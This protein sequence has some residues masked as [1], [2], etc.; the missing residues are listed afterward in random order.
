[1]LR[2][3][4]LILFVFALAGCGPTCDQACAQAVECGSL[5]S[6]E[7]ADCVSTCQSATDDAW[8]TCMNTEDCA[9][10]DACSL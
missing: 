7:S 9:E 5:D 1:M 3:V 4:A 6:A 10:V 2:C 8:L